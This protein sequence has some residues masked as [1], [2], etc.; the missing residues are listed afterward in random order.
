MTGRIAKQRGGLRLLFSVVFF[1]GR[2]TSH[3]PGVQAEN[4]HSRPAALLH[5]LRS[6]QR[7]TGERI[8][9]GQ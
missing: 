4:F 5:H 8:L 3:R 9:P 6:R 7:N 2:F 1:D